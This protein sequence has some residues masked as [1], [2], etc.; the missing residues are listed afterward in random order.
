MDINALRSKLAQLQK[1]GGKGS[2]LKWSPEEGTSVI[3][4][5]PYIHR[6]ENPFLEMFYHYEFKTPAGKNK[7]YLSPITYGEPDP[8]AE[9]CEELKSSGDKE[10]WKL[11]RKLEPKQ[12]V[13]VPILVRGKEKE[14]VKFWGFGSKMYQKLIGI[15]LDE[16]YGDFTDLKTGRDVTVVGTKSKAQNG[17]EFIET[18]IIVKPNQTPATTDTEIAKAIQS[19][20]KMEDLD[21]VAT[22]A[23]LKTALEQWANENSENT[24]EPTVDT[25]PN[26]TTSSNV[27][28]TVN[29][30]ITASDLD[31][32]LG[33]TPGA[34]T[35]AKELDAVEAEFDALFKQ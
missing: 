16:D 35:P 11:G 3:R 21:E 25:A 2:N 27:S 19:M 24:D 9:F 7:T 30:E 6:P 32:I 33:T 31:E 10:E 26:V 20:P 34:A 22:Y 4:I 17:R 8:I 13:F 12:R 5:L 28:T 29:T 23:T 15:L 14:G 18:D 1:Q